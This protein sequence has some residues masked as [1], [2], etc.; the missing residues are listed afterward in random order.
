MRA[1][2]GVDAGNWAWDEEEVV[3]VGWEMRDIIVLYDDVR[4]QLGGQQRDAML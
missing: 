2:L 1:V 3:D 4:A